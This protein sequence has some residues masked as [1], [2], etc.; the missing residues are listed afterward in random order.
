MTRAMNT[1]TQTTTAKTR[2][3]TTSTETTTGLYRAMTT[4]TETTTGLY[5][6]ISASP[7]T[8]SV[9]S[10]TMSALNCATATPARATTFSIRAASTKE[11]AIGN[12][13]RMGASLWKAANYSFQISSY[14][15][16]S[17]TSNKHQR[18]NGQS[19]GKR[20][21]KKFRFRYS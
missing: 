12:K 15:N 6:A 3:M 18:P 7:E 21:Y 2:A 5:R 4:S 9:R 16:F 8:M 11:N 13:N 17:T 20:I 14:L 1:S 10:E 19:S